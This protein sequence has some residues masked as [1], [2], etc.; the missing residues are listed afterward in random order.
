MPT[1]SQIRGGTGR[2]RAGCHPGRWQRDRRGRCSRRPAPCR[3]CSR[4]VA[5]PVGAGFVES[6][7]RPGG[8]ATGFTQFEYGISGKW[9]ELLKE[10]APRVTRAAVL[11]DPAITA[12]MGQFGAIQSVAPSFGV[13]L[14]PVDV[15][16]APEI[17]RAITAFARSSN[18]GLIVTASALAIVHRDLIITLAARHKLPAVYS[19]RYFVADGGLI[20]YGPDPVDQYRRAAG[21]VDRILKGEKPAD[22]PVQAPTKYEMVINLKTAKALGLDVPP[23]AA[24][25]RRR[26][27]RM[28]RREFITLLGG[29]AAWPLAARAQQAKLPTIGF[30]ARPRLRPGGHGPLLLCSGCA[31]SAGSRAAPSRSSIA[32]RRDA[33]SATPRSRPS[34]SGSRSTSSSRWQAQ[35]SRLKQ[36]TS[37]I[38]IVFALADDPVG[39]GLVASLA[40]PGGNVT[41]LSNQQSDLAGKRIELLREFVP[42][43]RRLAILANVGNSESVLEMD[44]VQTA[45]RNFGIEVVKLEIRRAEDIAPAFEALKRQ[46]DALY[47]VVVRSHRLNRTR[48]ITF[49]LAARLPTIIISREYVE[50]GALMSYGPNFPDLFRRAADYVDKILRGAKPG[51][52]PVEQPTKFDLVINLT[53]AKAL[54][55]D[56]PPTA[57]RPRRRGDR[58]KRRE[59]ITL[60]GGAAAAWPLAARAQQAARLAP[61]YRGRVTP[62]DRALDWR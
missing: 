59:F 25:P 12:G 27:D 61:R 44:E 35:S 20:S 54:G 32:G 10:I 13:E 24:R 17:E 39:T 4:S 40:R 42:D 2:A 3:S 38:P 21:Y 18:G 57:A 50:A 47:V 15:R 14:S 9:L 56:V 36:A 22:L 26:G 19:H 1:H 62:A 52:I 51:D 5:D 31:S 34:S 6:L 45:A 11:R 46:A 53:T 58:M 16:D 41:G 43:L 48:I 30:W 28:R 23:T 37:V 8:N 33:A 29:A 7:A 49:A 55:L 60:L